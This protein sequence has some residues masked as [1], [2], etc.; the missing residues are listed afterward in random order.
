MTTHLKKILKSQEIP[1][2]SGK[3]QENVR[4]NCFRPTPLGKIGGTNFFFS[5][6]LHIICIPTFQLV[7]PPLV[8]INCLV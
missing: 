6:R 1:E 5:L 2:W 8:E 4:G 7:A 3:S